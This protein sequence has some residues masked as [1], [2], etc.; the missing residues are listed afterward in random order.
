MVVELAK[1]GGVQ[2]VGKGWRLFLE[3]ESRLGFMA[4]LRSI[5]LGSVSLGMQEG[6]LV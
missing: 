6:L 5:F 1:V 2:D 4:S 3:K